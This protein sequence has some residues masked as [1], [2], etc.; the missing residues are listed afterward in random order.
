MG[1]FGQKPQQSIDVG[2]QAD[3]TLNSLIT[4]AICSEA[5]ENPSPSPGPPIATE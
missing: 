4:L 3:L 1:H 5:N 2:M